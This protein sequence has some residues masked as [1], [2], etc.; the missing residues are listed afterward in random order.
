VPGKAYPAILPSSSPSISLGK[1]LPSSVPA[2]KGV[3][4][5]TNTSKISKQPVPPPGFI[6]RSQLYSNFFRSVFGTG[7]GSSSGIYYTTMNLLYQ[8]INDEKTKGFI[9]TVEQ[10]LT[11]TNVKGVDS[12]SK[13]AYDKTV[14]DLRIATTDPDGNCFFQSIAIAINNYNYTNQ[15]IGIAT[16]IGYEV[17][18]IIYGGS[19]P[20]NQETIRFV[21]F[22]FLQGNAGYL[23]QMLEAQKEVLD[24]KNNEFRTAF[25]DACGLQGLA[26]L[27]PGTKIPRGDSGRYS[28]LYTNVVTSEYNKSHPGFASQTERNMPVDITQLY[29]PFSFIDGLITRTNSDGTIADVNYNVLE[30]Y[31]TQ[32]SVYWGD[33]TAIDAVNIVL[34]INTIVI[35]KGNQGLANSISSQI[36]GVFTNNVV[37]EMKHGLDMTKWTTF[38]FLYYI[39]DLTKP[40]QAAHYE[41]FTFLFPV[42][43]TETD[44]KSNI[45]TTY[46]ERRFTIFNKNDIQHPP[47][48]YML[49]LIFGFK[50]MSPGQVPADFDFFSGFNQSLNS[51]YQSIISR[52]GNNADK[53]KLLNN[54]FDLFLWQ[55]LEQLIT[56]AGCKR[57]N[58]NKKSIR[59]ASDVSGVPKSRRIRR[60]SAAES[61]DEA[62]TSGIE[63]GGI[64]EI[65]GGAV[66][67][68]TR[69]NYNYNYNNNYNNN[70]NYPNNFLKRDAVRDVSKI[71]YY[72]S[73]D[74]ELKK[75]S[76]LTP[77]E[78]SESKCTRKW[79]SVRK[80]FANFTGK[81]YAIPPVYDYS[82]KQTLKNK[83]N[84]KPNNVT[85]S[86]KPPPPQTQV[87]PPP[88][89]TNLENPTNKTGGTR[90]NEVK[91]IYLNGKH[92]KTMKKL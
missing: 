9:K 2:A 5:K 82:N 92:N 69:R 42:Q 15:E 78:I 55:Y 53:C 66:N 80:A 91:Q 27:V 14:A 71:G 76:P 33:A 25:D 49:L 16:R 30:Q 74:L 3:V 6:F 34:K 1:A 52:P 13:T 24:A 63:E 45:Q 57:T 40:D 89:K 11:T 12:I 7:K 56:D 75:G 28:T 59:F 81:T 58:R 54:L 38:L 19:T 39:E 36:T 90:K 83:S 32:G 41:L 72:I 47:P 79:N 22:D 44:S 31:I 23:F 48:L 68:R 62:D 60:S 46:P 64:S 73:I 26:I 21:V 70:N 88:P 10:S 61:G 8:G 51:S 67:R 29:Q 17:K 84:N 86:N 35:K 37:D 4:A 65:D 77:E 87:P 43:R 50:Y 85:K 20:F 18:G